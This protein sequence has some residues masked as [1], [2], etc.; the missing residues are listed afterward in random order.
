VYRPLV[1]LVENSINMDTAVDLVEVY[2]RLN[3]YLTLAEWQIQTLGVAGRWQTLTDVDIL[4]VR[5]PGEVYIADVHDPEQRLALSLTDELLLLEED[6]VD[7]VLGEVKEGEAEFNPS[8]TQHQ[9]LHTVLHRLA[10]IYAEGDLDKVVEELTTVGVCHSSARGGGRIRTRMVAFGRASELTVNA[11]PIGRVLE[12]TA[13][14]LQRYE[15]VLRS[16]R[17]H[18][19][20]VDTLKL[21]HKSGFRLSRGPSDAPDTP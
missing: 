14:L 16:A 21:I 5:F 3:G 18:S 11:V 15:D 2:L 12:S 4:G 19:P 1:S 17:F 20:S 8:F 13:E 10:W 6:S 7:V 9:T